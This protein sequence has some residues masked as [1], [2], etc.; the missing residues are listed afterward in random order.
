MGQNVTS[1]RNGPSW[2]GI[3]AQRP[4]SNPKV[5][6]ERDFDLAWG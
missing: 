5:E 2:D 1:V 6:E 4:E 3:S